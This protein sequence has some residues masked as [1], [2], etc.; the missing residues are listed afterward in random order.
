MSGSRGAVAGTAACSRTPCQCWDCSKATLVSSF[1]QARYG[2]WPQDGVALG[3][4][5]VAERR[6]PWGQGW[7]GREPSHAKACR[8][9]R[10]SA[11][12]PGLSLVSLVTTLMCQ[13]PQPG[14]ELGRISAK[15]EGT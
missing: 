7:L 12:S 13:R 10:N 1:L 2:P 6:L 9:E 4:G 5:T 14:A 15:R 3:R 8:D 11:G